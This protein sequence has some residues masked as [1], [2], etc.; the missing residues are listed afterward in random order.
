MLPI[1]QQESPGAA[2]DMMRKQRKYL[3]KADRSVF[4]TEDNIKGFASIFREAFRQGA[5]GV[6]E[7][8]KSATEYWGFDVE[9][10]N[11]PGIRLWYGSDDVNTP[12]HFGKWMAARLSQPLYKEYAGKSH[13][14]VW[15]NVE[16]ILE[17]MLS[18]K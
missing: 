3:R 6:T 18:D 8:S 9:D 14:T 2:E 1:V 13:F 11:Y 15:D 16:E 17:D 12:P 10:V 5:E 4:E 7:D